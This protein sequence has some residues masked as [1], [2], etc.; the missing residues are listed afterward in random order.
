MSFVNI[1]HIYQFILVTLQNYR[2]WVSHFV[3]FLKFTSAIGNYVKL[4]VNLNKMRVFLK[5]TNTVGNFAKLP[6]I[7]Q[8]YQFI[9]FT[10]TYVY[11]N[12]NFTGDLLDILTIFSSLKGSWRKSFS[13][14]IS[15]YISIFTKHSLFNNLYAT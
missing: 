9:T 4:P 5:F 12:G 11:I 1:Y 8:N 3:R 10:L 2:F 6:E 13:L 15:V 14:W 7:L